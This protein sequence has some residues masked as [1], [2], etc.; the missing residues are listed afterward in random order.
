MSMID[1]GTYGAKR[2]SWKATNPRDLLK[3]LIDKLGADEEAVREQFAAKV[4]NDPDCLDTVI[5]YWVANNYRSIV[6][7]REIVRR[8]PV[9]KAQTVENIAKHVKTRATALVLLELTMPNNKLYRDCTE[10]DCRKFGGWHLKVADKLKLKPNQKVGDA[11]SE[12]EVR[13]LFRS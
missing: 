13:A 10:K 12:K 8:D 9:A 7:P 4:K 11:L 6:H 3:Q 2:Q 1:T 5:E